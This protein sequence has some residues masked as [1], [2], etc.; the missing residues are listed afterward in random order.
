MQAIFGGWVAAA[1]ARIKVGHAVEKEPVQT[2]VT[3]A[4]VRMVHRRK[5]TKAAIVVVALWE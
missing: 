2:R 4:V 1:I 5:G 3:G